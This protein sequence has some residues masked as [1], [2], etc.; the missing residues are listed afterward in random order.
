[1]EEEN[2]V[3]FMHILS[4]ELEDQKDRVQTE[5]NHSRTNP[6]LLRNIKGK[7]EI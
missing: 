6:L 7:T 3:R 4:P 5:L 2:W 1:V